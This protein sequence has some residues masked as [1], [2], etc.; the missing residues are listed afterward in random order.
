MRVVVVIPCHHRVDLLKQALRAL[1]GWPV[2][3]VDDS[4]QGLSLPSGVQVARTAGERGFAAA[5]NLGLAAAEA[6]GATHALVL[7][8]DAVPAPG[9]IEALTEAWGP[10]TGA[11]GP[12]IYAADGLESAGVD[13]AWWGRVR[14]RRT[15]G[16]ARDPAASA[17]R[18]GRPAEVSA[19]SGAAMM[20]STRE[21]FDEGYRHGF[22]DLALCRSLRRRGQ[23]ILLVPGGRVMHLGGA[24]LSRRSRAAQRYAV[25]G[26]LRY[27]D[28]G[29][30]GGLAVGLALAQVLR[31]GG[32]GDRLLGVLDGVR[33]FRAAQG[34][35]S[36][37]AADMASSSPGSS[38]AR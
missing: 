14:Q 20:I 19:I 36:G 12:L 9:C 32:P 17:L 26:H 24:S 35:A 8:D 10:D 13:E 6:Q 34:E 15:L 23:K 22:E 7:N 1:T 33:D 27:L 5:V 28:G 29:W 2:L 38:T 31:E 11:A 37:R 18:E 3:V 16:P 30:R 25:A 21:R 4:P